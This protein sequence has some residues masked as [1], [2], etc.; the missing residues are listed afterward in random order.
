LVFFCRPRILSQCSPPRSECPPPPLADSSL[1]TPYFVFYPEGS[2]SKN[3]FAVVPLP[4]CFFPP[5][6]DPFARRFFTECFCQM[7]LRR[8]FIRLDT[9]HHLSHFL[10]PLS[11]SCVRLFWPCFY[12][13]PKEMVQT[14]GARFLSVSF[15]LV[16][17]KQNPI[18][19]AHPRSLLFPFPFFLFL[20]RPVAW[21]RRFLF[22]TAFS[23]EG[24]Y[25]P[26]PSL[27]SVFFL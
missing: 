23:Q 10:H 7:L 8:F 9:P 16:E 26:P 3:G 4:F 13:P 21:V 24:L 2:I 14:A 22:S 20:D 19:L 25:L 12:R 17:D 27:F 1:D 15:F 6:S 5:P 11:K 18:F